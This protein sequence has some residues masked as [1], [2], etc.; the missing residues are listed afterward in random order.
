[1]GAGFGLSA[2]LFGAIDLE[3]G[4][5]AQSNF[6]DYRVLRINEM[7][8]VEV[9]VPAHLRAAIHALRTPPPRAVLHGTICV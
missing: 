6:H 3:D 8:D 7:P 2:V 5:I 9:H 1:L 4:R